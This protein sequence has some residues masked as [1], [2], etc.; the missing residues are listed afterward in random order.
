MS[1]LNKWVGLSLDGY[2]TQ[3]C[4]PKLLKFLHIVLARVL[5]AK[6]VVHYLL[7]WECSQWN[8]WQSLENP[9]FMALRTWL[10][11]GDK[12]ETEYNSCWDLS[13]ARPTRLWYFWVLSRSLNQDLQVHWR[14][15]SQLCRIGGV[16]RRYWNC[17]AEDQ[18][19]GQVH[20]IWE[21]KELR[22]V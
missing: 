1:M 2:K 10:L 4:L 13:K 17:C 15:S 18:Q 3:K 21:L 16:L 12:S 9:F 6:Q 11:S 5:F 8:Q 14:I 7:R 22:K 19:I 20:K